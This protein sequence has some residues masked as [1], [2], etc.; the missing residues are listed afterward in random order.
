MGLVALL[1]CMVLPAQQTTSET[2]VPLDI[3]GIAVE[4]REQLERGPSGDASLLYWE[5]LADFY[6]SRDYQPVW[7]DAQWANE[8]ARAMLAVL[9]HAGEEGLD[10]SA[11][12]LP[13]LE[14]LSQGRGQHELLQFELLL[15]N[16]FFDYSRD[17]HIGQIEPE[18]STL[19]WHI[20]TKK[21]GS[22]TLLQALSANEDFALSIT[23]LAPAH[24][25]YQ[26]LRDALARYHKIEAAGGWPTIPQGEKL[27]LGAEGPRVALLR[28]RLQLEGD[29]PF[30]PLTPQSLFDQTLHYAVERFQLRHGLERDGVVGALTLAELNVPV[31]RRIEQIRANMERWRWLPE[32]LGHRHIIVNISAFQLSAYDH[33]ERQFTMDAIIGT[34]ETPTPQITGDLH[35]VVFNPYWTIPRKIA[36]EE[37]IPKQQRNPGYFRSQ[38]IRVFS[39]WNG[40]TELA[41]GGIDWTRLD[42]NNF[43]Y[44]LRQDPGP[45]NP[46][47]KLKFI[48]TNNYRVYLHDTPAQQLFDQTERS[49][50]HGCIRVAQPVLLAHYLL[51]SEAAAPWSE[52]AIRSAIATGATRE[53]ELSSPLPV[54]LL[55]LTAWVGDDGAVHFRKDLYGEDELLLI[56]LP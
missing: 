32:Q 45:K 10:P 17:I 56:D 3:T 44:M 40:T 9:R 41:P 34:Q 19:L 27:R 35:T 5:K 6:A 39:D 28:R 13:L 23:G 53:V 38:G 21:T 42:W 48:F 29:L 14:Q 25:G 7:L 52:E 55:Y 20:A 31:S 2:P 46:L 36:L 54:Y 43:V 11:Y 12:P 22:A 26:R 16:T 49:F 30:S 18:W 37:I 51:A 8:R 15:S 4:L 1:W 50:S 33:G 47:G 24:P